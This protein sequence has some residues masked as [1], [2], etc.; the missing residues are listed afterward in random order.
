M[1]T[2]FLIFSLLLTFSILPASAQFKVSPNNRYILKDNK[3]FFWLGD[4]AWELFHRLNRAEVDT[5]FKRRSEQ[6]FTV[7]QAVVL[8][9]F[10]GLHTPNANGD[11]PLINDDPSK[12][13]EKYFR[14]VDYVIS[15]AAQYNIN[16]AMLPTW[17]DKI[18][19]DK[20]GIGPEIFNATNAAVYAS[21]LAKRYGKKTNVIW[22]LGGDRNP[23]NETDVNIWRSMAQA[24]M[25][26]TGNRA[27]I[28]FHPQPNEKG[29]A[30]W[31]HNDEWLAF[32]MFQTGH[33][34]DL[35]EYD[36]IQTGYDM[37]PIKPVLNGE[38]IYEDHAV[39]FDEKKLGISNDYDA[40]RA[41]YLS[42]FAGA[43][44][45]TY[46]CHD[47]WQFYS[48]KREGLNGPHV[49]WQKAMDLPGANQMKFVRQL[50]ESFPMEDRVPDQSIIKE[51]RYFPK[52]RIQS[53]RG[54]DY[55]MVYSS[56]GDSFTL[57]G[58]KIEGGK[59]KGFWLNPRT[60][61]ST[62]VA[63]FDNNGQTVFKPASSG[64]GQDWVLV[65][66]DAEKNYEF[67]K[68]NSVL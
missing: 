36:K 1:K 39:C 17:G 4:T 32:N 10:D 66:F 60:G 28:T 42:L 53:T 19:K 46:G 29:S 30:E 43:F 3:P 8:A 22:V 18:Y 50:L 21:W 5:Y 48:P 20:W 34:R 31:F 59:L 52:D 16:I 44:G 63:A 54:N 45:H 55:L 38:P 65:L 41:A 7:V 62:M 24:I 23:R 6:G 35:A 58:G 11:L 14:H 37:T 56:K 9:E 2:T 61:A 12:P 68:R 33:C 25:K 15:K 51:N 57:N 47:I 26:E 64:A 13:N 67:G 40:R 49:Y 27:M